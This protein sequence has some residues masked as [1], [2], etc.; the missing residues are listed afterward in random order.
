[1]GGVSLHFHHSANVSTAS[2]SL[3]PPPLLYFPPS[4]PPLH[5]SPLLLVLCLANPPPQD[6]F[7]HNSTC[8]TR[9]MEVHNHTQ[10]VQDNMIPLA[11]L[12]EESLTVDIDFS[13]D[14]Y[15]I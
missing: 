2:T 9:S 5:F 6:A 3:C 15:N 11:P 1:M 7:T 13:P 8:D 14:W 12:H 10:A 4:L